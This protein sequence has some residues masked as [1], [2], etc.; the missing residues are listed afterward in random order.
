MA[1][2]AQPASLSPAIWLLPS[3]ARWGQGGA[4]STL[5]LP[6]CPSGHW[7]HHAYLLV[8]RT[9]LHAAAPTFCLLHAFA[10]TRVRR[11]HEAVPCSPWADARETGHQRGRE[12]PGKPWA[13]RLGRARRPA[14]P[15]FSARARGLGR[16]A[17]AGPGRAGSAAGRPARSRGPRG[18]VPHPRAPG[19]DAHRALGSGS[20]A[21]AAAPRA[22]LRGSLS[23]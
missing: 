18:R 1:L 12:T 10:A 17:W 23:A 14:R 9:V 8:P 2:F 15:P 4:A 5:P 3:V 7:A 20:R 6:P 21:P 22:H 11:H 19:Q 16:R 13:L